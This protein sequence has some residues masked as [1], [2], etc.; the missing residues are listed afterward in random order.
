MK[1]TLSIN[2]ELETKKSNKFFI[3]SQFWFWGIIHVQ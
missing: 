2:K 3:T 1:K